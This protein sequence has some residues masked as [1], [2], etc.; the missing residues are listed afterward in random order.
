[1]GILT[2]LRRKKEDFFIRKLH[3]AATRGNLSKVKAL[4]KKHDLN[5]PDKDNRT[6]LHIAC[7][8][9]HADIVHFLGAKNAELN[10]LDNK[11]RTPLV[12]AVQ[13]E[14]ECCVLS[15]L[16]HKADPNLADIN[17][18]TA[19]HFA[20]FIPSIPLAGHLLRNGASINAKNKEGCSPLHLAVSENHL[21]MV[22]YLLSKV[23]DINAS[24][25]SSRT[26]LMIAANNGYFRMISM[27]LWHFADDSIKDNSGWT[28]NDHAVMNRHYGCSDLIINRGTRGR[29]PQSA[30][31]SAGKEAERLSSP[32]V[33]ESAMTLEGPA[34]DGE[35]P[36]GQDSEKK[37]ASLRPQMTSA[38]QEGVHSQVT[39]ADIKGVLQQERH[40]TSSESSYQPES[41]SLWELSSQQ[42]LSSEPEDISSLPQQL[43]KA[44][45]KTSSLECHPATLSV[46]LL[47]ETIQRERD[48]AQE[49][50]ESLLQAENVPQ[51]NL[52]FLEAQNKGL[53]REALSDE[54]EK[55]KSERELQKTMGL[56][57][58]S[59][60]HIHDL[61]NALE[62]KQC[63]VI[64]TVQKLQQVL[65]SS[66][67]AEMTIKQLQERVM[68]TLI[69]GF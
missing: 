67:A 37:V 48:L 1:M 22:S 40:D 7:A 58:Q 50:L 47:L 41:S 60:Q 28:A 5:W 20:A 68:S 62:S 26:P 42:E 53:V 27:L 17:G 15:L 4:S 66:S 55:E 29:P 13:S 9:G 24:D 25:N 6:P 3:Q 18:N 61:K 46:T 19:L 31:N 63:E 43:D 64:L 23:A 2:F 14:Q 21:D 57:I 69:C 59:K 54:Q 12:T 10:L 49:R 11:G 36:G 51:K 52:G 30:S 39:K 16:K 38:L 34:V 45:A 56:Y 8:F 32:I 44:E 33:T 65:S 35:A